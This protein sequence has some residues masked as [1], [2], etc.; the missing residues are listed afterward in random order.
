MKLFAWLGGFAAPRYDLALVAGRI[1]AAEKSVAALGP[2]ESARTGGWSDRALAGSRAG[3]LFWGAL[4]LVVVALLVVVA[5]LLP[6][7]PAPTA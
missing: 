5:Q 4:I 2:E 7:P 3:V 6:K 1:L